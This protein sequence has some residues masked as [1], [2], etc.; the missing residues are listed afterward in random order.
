MTEVARVF[1]EDEKQ[2]SSKNDAEVECRWQEETGNVR[3]QC[4][5]EE[6]S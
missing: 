1:E 2:Q 3:G 4:R 6:K 5:N